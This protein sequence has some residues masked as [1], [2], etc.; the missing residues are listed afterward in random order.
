MGLGI[1]LTP[2][3]DSGYARDETNQGVFSGGVV[4]CAGEAAVM[5]VE[6]A[7]NRIY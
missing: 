1:G 7:A 5:V 3:A 6:D 2:Y 4:M